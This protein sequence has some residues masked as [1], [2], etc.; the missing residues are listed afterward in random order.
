[1][2]EPVAIRKPQEIAN[3]PTRVMRANNNEATM[4]E[5]FHVTH[6]Q[7]THTEDPIGA[8]LNAPVVRW[9]FSRNFTRHWDGLVYAQ[10]RLLNAVYDY[11]AVRQ[12]AC[13]RKRRTVG[14]RL[15]DIRR[16]VRWSEAF[17]RSLDK[18]SRSDQDRCEREI[19][20]RFLKKRAVPFVEFWQE[21]IEAL[22]HGISL[23]IKP[24]DIP[25][26]RHVVP[27]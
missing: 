9:D 21:A 10:V 15:D 13:V 18:A 6:P 11:A 3:L 5:S 4:L 12:K 22:D 20:A 2:N 7:D 26:W 1:M 17:A 16:S 14:H 25:I 19:L 27:E 24:A 8:P 23:E